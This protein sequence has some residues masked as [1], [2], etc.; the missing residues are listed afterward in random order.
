MRLFPLLCLLIAALY[1]CKSEDAMMS[2]LMEE[3]M[4]YKCK[5]H[6]STISEQR[7][8]IC[9]LTLNFSFLTFFL[10]LLTIYSLPNGG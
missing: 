7:V 6:F 3:V 8:K 10:C 9:R 2:D 5:S 4:D 1:Q